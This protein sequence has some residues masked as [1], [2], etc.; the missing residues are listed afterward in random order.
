MSF[1][2]TSGASTAIS[3]KESSDNNS[4]HAPPGHRATLRAVRRVS[5][6]VARTAGN[7][8][9][10]AGRGGGTSLP[11]MVLL[12]LRPNA[13]ADLA[14]DLVNGSAVISAT[15]GK[16]TTARLLVSLAESA[17]QS[18]VANT[19]GANLLRGVTSA[20][21]TAD[22]EQPRPELGIF[23]VD[24][25]AL[26]ATVAQIRPRVITLMNLFRDQLDRYGELESLVAKWET[27]IASLEP[28]VVL[29]LNADDPA[30]ASL[31]AHRPN[32][33]Y[34]GVDDDAALRGDLAHAADSTR[35]R[36]CDHELVYAGTTIGHF[37]RWSCPNGDSA[38]PTPDIAAT[39]VDLDGVRGQTVTFRRPKGAPVTTSLQLPGLHNAYNAA[40]ALATAH[41]LGL[42]VGAVAPALAGTAPAFG[43]AEKVE[44]QGRDVLVLL[45]KNPAGVNENVRTV[46]LD[47]APLHVLALLNDRTADGRDVSWIWDVDYEP[48]LDRLEQLTVA[49]DRS[50]DLALRFRYAGLDPTRMAV[51]ADPAAALDAAIASTPVGSM[52]YVLPTYTALLDLRRVLTDRGI[53]RAFWN[54]GQ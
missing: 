39:T 18:I 4:D 51:V 52:L 49:G 27:M 29:V 1:R 19:A 48:L 6:F 33:V 42:D 38:R 13:A 41:A 26:P 54:E 32:T 50:G 46:L 10:L 17:G 35:C 22:R 28:S 9:R 11:G 44:V 53:T 15:N 43:R 47:D 45:A 40:A 37:G 12:R 7:M 24:E 20:L 23:E 30:V 16:T 14:A 25:A 34:F 31:G 36:V 5:E 8:S 3:L 21:L 2:V